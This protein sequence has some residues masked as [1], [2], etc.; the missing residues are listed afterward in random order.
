MRTLK[1]IEYVCDG[2][3]TE[4]CILVFHFF[5]CVKKVFKQKKLWGGGGDG[6]CLSPGHNS[7]RI[8][9]GQPISGKFFVLELG[10]LE[11]FFWWYIL[12]V[13]GSWT[14]YER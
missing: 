11:G 6:S 10:A 1:E 12:L 7:H 5:R 9:D 14:K 8:F 2:N 4:E 13:Y 3:Q